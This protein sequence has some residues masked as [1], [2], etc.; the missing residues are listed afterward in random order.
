VID[1]VC[2]AADKNIEAAIDGILQRSGSL[3]IRGVRCETIVHPNRDP[4]CFHQS[5]ELLRGYRDRA[6]HGLVVLDR[7]WDGAPPAAGEE[8]EERLEGSL[9]LG[10][11]ARA[12][13]IDPELEVWVFSDSPHVARSLGW[14]GGMI[15]LREALA[16]Q[17][18][19]RAEQA[20]PR[21]PKTAVEWALRRAR[22]PRS[23]AL[24]RD[25]ALHVGLS[26][27]QDR[28]FLRLR[29]LLVDWFAAPGSEI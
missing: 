22:K 25:L 6:A 16:A 3:G 7:A 5:G 21:D 17:D 15:G 14:P 8:L 28:A 9:G 4:G 10:D 13:V 18:L 11:W 29:R 12:V 19:W 2:L 27:C 26:H 24:F 23:S 1:L 20:K